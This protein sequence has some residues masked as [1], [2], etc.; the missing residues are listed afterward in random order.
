[1]FQ[2]SRP[3]P[4]SQQLRLDC[5]TSDAVEVLPARIGLMDS[6]RCLGRCPR[7]DRT[8]FY[9]LHVVQVFERFISR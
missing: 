6:M 5:V 4:C 3:N 7:V 2:V 1:M 9:K 8:L